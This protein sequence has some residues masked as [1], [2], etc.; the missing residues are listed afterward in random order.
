[1]HVARKNPSIRPRWLWPFYLV[2]PLLPLGAGIARG[3]E[4]PATPARPP[5]AAVAKTAQAE[6]EQEIRPLLTQFCA[7]C[8]GPE[9]PSG[10]VDLSR[11][12]DV[13]SLQRDQAAGRKILTLVRER[14]M[15]PKGMPQPTETQRERLTLWLGHTLDNADERVLP[16]DPGRT[17]VRRLSRAEYNNTVRDL[18]GVDRG[19]RIGFRLTAAAAA[20]ST[21]TPPRCSCRRS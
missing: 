6:Y 19:R 4:E 8:H 18:F 10:G 13:P 14:T 9:K 12:K 11:F 7:P 3:V 17:L 2:L 15:P 1:M 5:K 21:T 16:K 20:A